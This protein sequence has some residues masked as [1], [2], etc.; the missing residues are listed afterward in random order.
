ML[1]INKW[2]CVLAGRQ[3][4]RRLHARHRFLAN[5]FHTWLINSKINHS[6]AQSYMTTAW[7]VIQPCPITPHHIESCI[8]FPHI[9]KIP[10]QTLWSY[11]LVTT[12]CRGC[13]ESTIRYA[14]LMK[15]AETRRMVFWFSCWCWDIS[16]VLYSRLSSVVKVVGLSCGGETARNVAH[17]LTYVRRCF[18]TFIWYV[19]VHLVVDL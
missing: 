7:H 1:T 17:H 9:L 4:S 13:G 18:E 19:S 5:T 2:H 16:Q 8:C 14:S 10:L 12:H 11:K 15:F 6:S 3:T